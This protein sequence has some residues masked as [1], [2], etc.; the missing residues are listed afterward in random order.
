MVDYIYNVTSNRPEHGSIINDS[1]EILN[2][3]NNF[4]DP[5]TYISYTPNSDFHHP[6]N[7]IMNLFRNNV[8]KNK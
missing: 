7:C 5:K 1:I 8:S 3:Y 4:E 2:R 6:L